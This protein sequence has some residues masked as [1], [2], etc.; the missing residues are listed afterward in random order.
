M[1]RKEFLI[2]TGIPI[3]T[4]EDKKILPDNIDKIH[5][6]KWKKGKRMYE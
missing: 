5:K 6:L 2:H 3:G 1:S 4:L